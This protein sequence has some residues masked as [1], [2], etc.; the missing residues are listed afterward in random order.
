MESLRPRGVIEYLE[1][2]WRKKLQIFMV[3]A[4][5]LI[6][7]LL[8][9]RRI[10]NLYE[11]HSLI[12]ISGQANDEQSPPGARF[13][14]LTQQMIS[15]GNLAKIANRYD[16]Y[17]HVPGL[18]SDPDA[19]IEH[20]RKE[21]KLDIK[22]R[23]YYPEAPE[24]LAISYRYSDPT[25]ARRVMGDLVS[26]FEQANDA[27]REQASRE[28]EQFNAKIA[29]VETQLHALAPQRE[30][31][32]LRSG[33][34][35]SP[36]MA[37]S[38]ARAQ[39]LTIANSIDSLD[40]KKFTLE[41]QIE[42]QKRQ[43]TDQEK[44]VSSAALVNGISASGAYGVLLARKAEV[45]GQIKD[46]ATFATAKNPKMI[47]AQTQ[48]AGINREI[49]RLESSSGTTPA[50]AAVS[51]SP[52]AR[53]LRAMQRELQRLQIELDVT[54]RDMSRKTLNLRALPNAETTT[55]FKETIQTDGL[56]RS[57]AEYERLLGRYT[58][59]K[60]KQ[61]SL[62]KISGGGVSNTPMFQVIDSPDVSRNPVAPRRNLLIL[63]GLGIALGL[64]LL[65]TAALEFSRL[66]M[67]NN[68]R[69]VEYYLG[70]P[71]LALIPETL[72][73]FERGRRRRLS[74]LR[75]LG[76]GLLSAMMIPIFV[77]VLDHLQIFQLLGSR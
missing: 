27:M 50:A 28:L 64:G 65:V 67:I 51:L 21:I 34:V 22:M 33:S 54:R 60:D 69:D 11:S 14:A 53:E 41:R 45:E 66:L 46:L 61:D 52:E 5:V 63:L 12:V 74:L 7:T 25:T 13:A 68:D 73:P 20:L 30:L 6:A 9:I 70:A 29:E 10:P 42:E 3:A 48:L 59:L 62:Q 56:I 49:G 71:V 76:L 36:D 40:D 15:R 72:T 32:I 47:Q 75:W 35:G 77:A 43:I 1:I 8:I 55:A 19:T 44:Q 23:T 2:L 37:S 58:W 4:S 24:S 57:K 38:A 16:L 17:S 26:M 31:A 18:A 39:R